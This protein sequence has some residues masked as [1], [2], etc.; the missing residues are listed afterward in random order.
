[1]AGSTCIACALS[2][3]EK[4]PLE[5]ATPD[6]KKYTSTFHGESNYLKFDHKKYTPKYL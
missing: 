6:I 5:P 2:I 1:M 4:L 3:R